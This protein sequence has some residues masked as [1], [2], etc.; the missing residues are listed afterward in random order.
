MTTTGDDDVDDKTGLTCCAGPNSG[1]LNECA[2]MMESRT[3]SVKGL[4][5]TVCRQSQKKRRR[6]RW[7][8]E[9]KDEVEGLKKG[10][11]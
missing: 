1:P 8:V 4:L 10:R 3:P 5:D 7:M 9:W 2:I 11:G 6:A